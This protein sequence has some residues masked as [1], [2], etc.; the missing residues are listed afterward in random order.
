MLKIYD[1]DEFVNRSRGLDEIVLFG[2]GKRIHDVEK[3]FVNTEVADKVS[4]VIDNDINKQG[5]M[6][7]LWGREFE[8]RGLKEICTDNISNRMLLVTVEDY[9][10]L[11]DDMLANEKL[12]EVEVVCFSH[13]IG[14]EKEAKSINKALPNRIRLEENQIIPK[15]IHYCWFGGQPLPDKYKYYMESW[16]KFCPDYEIIEWN[17]SNYDISKC[18]YMYDAYQKKM[19][20]FASDYARIDIVYHNGGIYLDTDVE[21]VKN[22]DDLLFQKGFAGFEDEEFVNFGLGFGAVKELPVLKEMLMYYEK[23][24]FLHED[25]SLNLTAIPIY[26]TDVLSKHGLVMNG[27]YQ[28][29]ADMTIYPAKVL[30]GKCMYTMRTMIMPQTY[31]IHQYDGSWATEKAHRINARMAQDMMMYQKADTDINR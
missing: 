10:S 17:E 7:K 19:W 31:A 12:K 6:I 15:K 13:I 27:E 5:N 8:I 14:L 23:L 18:K 3:F 16:R 25:G 9:G 1:M 24:N 22:I 30:A 4:K 21:L 29:I 2:A 11:L 26:V 28:R 20:G